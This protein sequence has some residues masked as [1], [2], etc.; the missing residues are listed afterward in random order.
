M[1]KSH[2]EQSLVCMEHITPAQS[3]VLPKFAVQNVL[4]QALK[5]LLFRCA[6]GVIVIIVGNGLNNP[7]S[8][9]GQGHLHFP[10]C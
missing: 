4:K 8:N 3:Y 9:P 7:S 2:I 5:F 6:C 1:R 10:L